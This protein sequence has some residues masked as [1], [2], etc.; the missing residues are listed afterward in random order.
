M[1]SWQDWCGMITCF[2]LRPVEGGVMVGLSHVHLPVPDLARS[3][4]FN[5]DQLGLEVGNITSEA[6]ADFPAGL[7]I[8][9]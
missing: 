6:M 9:V 4:V 2:C 1:K 5:R 7:A 3:L 8:P